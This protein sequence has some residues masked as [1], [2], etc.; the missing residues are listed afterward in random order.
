MTMHRVFMNKGYIQI[1]AKFPSGDKVWPAI[2]LISEDLKWGP[3]WDMFE[4]F[5]YREDVGSDNMGMHLCYGQW[6]NEKWENKWI[7]QFNERFNC[8]DW[9]T[10]GFEWNEYFAKW[11]IDGKLM[12]QLNANEVDEWPDE[13]MY[14]VLNNGQRTHSPDTGTTW[15]NYFII[16]YIELYQ[17]Q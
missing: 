13:D 3:E 15:P 2:W 17:I 9:H 1:K 14:I 12:H 5:G 10:Y 11:Y 8:E 6:P 16:D 7:N 4:Y